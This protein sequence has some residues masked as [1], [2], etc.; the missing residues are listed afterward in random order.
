MRP[1]NQ[2]LGATYDS[3]AEMLAYIERW[4][5]AA[6]ACGRS[7]EILEAAYPADSVVVAH[8][9]QKHASS[10]MQAGDEA[11]A[12]KLYHDVARVLTLHY[13]SAGSEEAENEWKMMYGAAE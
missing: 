11:T 10:V 3:L 2:L 1:H 9:R 12:V 8:Q 4:V 6:A 13:G 5:A 7:V